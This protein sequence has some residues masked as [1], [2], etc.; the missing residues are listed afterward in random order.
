MSTPAD[1]TR[2]AH[3]A[4]QSAAAQLRRARVLQG[5]VLVRDGDEIA[6]AAARLVDLYAD[7]V[8]TRAAAWRAAFVADR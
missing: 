8:A 4:H 5:A 1:D 3:R 6:Q 7:Q 2:R